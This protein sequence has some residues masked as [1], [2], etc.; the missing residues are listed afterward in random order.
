MASTVAPTDAHAQR[1]SAWRSREMTCVAGTG[2]N[3]SACADEFLDER[4]DVGVSAYGT[5]ELADRDPVLRSARA[6][7]CRGR[8]AGTT[9][10]A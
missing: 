7:S 4:V 1:N 2:R 10:Q 5:R 8:P 6:G 9:A 3:P